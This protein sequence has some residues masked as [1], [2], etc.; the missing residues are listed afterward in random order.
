MDGLRECHTEWS[1]SNRQGEMSYG[2]PYTYNLKGNDTNELTK[3]T[4]WFREQA[5]GCQA[6]GWGKGELGN[7]G[8]TCTHCYILNG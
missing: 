7:M 6:E 1:K 5:Y 3:Q 8:W 2:I 4:R